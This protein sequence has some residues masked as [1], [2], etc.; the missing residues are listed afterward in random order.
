MFRS[1]IDKKNRVRKESPTGDKVTNV[2]GWIYKDGEYVYA[3]KKKHPHYEE[4]QAARD[5]VDLK[6]I[7]ERY[8]AGDENALDVVN[9]FYLDTVNMPR[10]MAEL[11]DAVSNA[12]NVFDSMPT[13]I[14]EHYNNNAAT[15]YK[16]YGSETFD[17]FMNDYRK[18]L[19]V[20]DADKDR[21]NTAQTV[22]VEPVLKGEIKDE[23]ESK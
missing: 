12:Q 22:I 2:K 20:S 14:K 9:G 13:E 18:A 4:T 15:F 16:A 1:I 21:V 17:N 5:S 11:Y 3:V 8:K 6:K 19:G 7:F 23:Q 10:N